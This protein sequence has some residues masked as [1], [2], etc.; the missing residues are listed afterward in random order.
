MKTNF[1]KINQ[2][3]LIVYILLYVSLILGF[4]YNEDVAGGGE[5]DRSFQKNV[6]SFGFVDGIKGFLFIFYPTNTIIHSP[7]YY[8]LIHKLENLINNENVFRFF[9]NE[10]IFANSINFN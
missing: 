8:I 10:Y 2:L 1:F 6:T 4:I 7:V 3:I 9:F 5:L